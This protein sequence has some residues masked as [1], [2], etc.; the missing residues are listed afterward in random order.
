MRDHRAD[1]LVVNWVQGWNPISSKRQASKR[2][3][4]G[5]EVMI[6]STKL[7]TAPK[8]GVLVSLGNN[9]KPAQFGPH[10]LRRLP[11]VVAL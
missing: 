1:W 7:R 2:D 6:S 5:P 3:R 11:S 8:L 9:I 10:T 4:A